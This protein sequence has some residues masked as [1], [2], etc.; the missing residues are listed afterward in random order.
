MM[1]GEVDMIK[2]LEV[3]AADVDMTLSAKDS[4]LPQITI[5]ALKELHNHGVKLGLATG[6]E[7]TSVEKNKGIN[8]QLGFEFDFI[9]GMNGGM[10]FDRNQNKSYTMDMLSTDEMKDILTDLMPLIEKERISVNAEGS[11]LHN[12]M[13]INQHLLDMAKRRHFTLIDKTG[14]VE[15]YCEKPVYKFLFRTE[16]HLAPILK[17]MVKDKYEDKYQMIETFPG[18]IE[19]MTNGISKGTGLKMYAK[20]NHIDLNHVI[21]F[22]DNEND[23]SLLKASGWGVCLKDGNPKTKQIADAITDYDCLDGGVGH[24]LFDHILNNKNIQF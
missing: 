22:G 13:N 15:G 18:T 4:A 11:G 2:K 12:V 5:D 21:A 23:N 24:Y 20:W 7:I 6:R 1:G 14:D 17:K 9:V 10:V 8:W 3:F 19:L 16:E